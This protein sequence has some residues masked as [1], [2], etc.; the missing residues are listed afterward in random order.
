MT[1]KRP[2]TRWR[3]LALVACVGAG[4][5]ALD[6]AFWAIWPRVWISGIGTMSPSIE[7][8]DLVRENRWALR[9]RDPVPGEVIVW[10]VPGVPNTWPAR[11]AS[12]SR[13]PLLAGRVVAV[14]GDAVSMKGADLIVNG[15]TLPQEKM[16]TGPD[17]P[18]VTAPRF[19]Q[20]I[21][22][23]KVVTTYGPHQSPR[24]CL[25]EQPQ[26]LSSDQFLLATDDR[27][28]GRMY[29]LLLPRIYISGL[30]DRDRRTGTAP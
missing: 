26:V 1:R 15:A 13:A 6:L 10:M 18:E 28:D 16:D 25:S 4:A 8:G 12:A 14:P 29:C 9:G 24:P 22:Q 17:A 5:W 2:A 21:G 30:I 11:P 19:L 23:R 3:I 20:R 7:F 27:P